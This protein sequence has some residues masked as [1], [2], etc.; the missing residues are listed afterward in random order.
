MQ[1]GEGSVESKLHPGD[2]NIA[3]G[4]VE[5]NAGKRVNA[6]ML[7]A[8]GSGPGAAMFEEACILVNESER[9]EFRET[10]GALLDRTQQ[11]KVAHP[12]GGFLDVAVHHGR[13]RRNT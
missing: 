13:C 5:Q 10:A 8:Q 4:S 7:F 3:N 2:L 11:E 6:K 1:T 12:I 9:N